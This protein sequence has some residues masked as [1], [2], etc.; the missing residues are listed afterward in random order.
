MKLE[1]DNLKEILRQNSH[2]YSDNEIKVLRNQIGYQH[3]LEVMEI[4]KLE[5]LKLE[6]I[7]AQLNNIE[8]KIKIGIDLKSEELKILNIKS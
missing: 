4:A 2:L 5:L 7:A 6:V 3:Y 1:S 8:K